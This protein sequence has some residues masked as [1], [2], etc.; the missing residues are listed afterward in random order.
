MPVPT[1]LADETAAVLPLNYLTAYAMIERCAGLHTGQSFLIH[2]AAGGVGTAALELA[3]VLG[4]HAYGTA[5]AQ[6]H[7]LVKSLGGIP[8]SR[9]RAWVDELAKLRPQGVDAAFDSFGLASFRASWKAL[10]SL[11]TLVCYGVSPSID[12]GTADFLKGLAF[13]GVRRIVGGTRRVRICATPGMVKADPRWFQVAMA[14]ILEWA[15]AGA[16]R[17][18]LA[19]VVSWARVQEAHRALAEG[20]VKGK[21]L[22]DFSV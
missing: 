10:S 21:L 15:A 11:G 9:G 4:L 7:D 22:L 3:R 20:A 6:K 5:S 17:P 14:R 2:G 13:L 8:L 19:G 16:F 1:G 18:V 12:G